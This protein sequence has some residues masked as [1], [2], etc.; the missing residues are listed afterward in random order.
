MRPPARP[1]TSRTAGPAASPEQVVRPCVS[2]QVHTGVAGRYALHG[3]GTGRYDV[4]FAP[5]NA[6]NYLSASH[7]RVSVRVGT[8]RTVSGFLVAGGAIAGTV[9][10]SQAGNATLAGICVYLTTPGGGIQFATTAKSGSYSFIRLTQGTYYVSLVGGCG[11]LGSY[12]PQFYRAGASTGS[13]SAATATPI[14]LSVGESYQANVAMLPGGTIAG[15]VTGQPSGG[16]LR[17]VCVELIGQ[18]GFFLG[19]LTPG[20]PLIPPSFNFATTD[21]AGRY[22]LPNLRP[23]LYLVDFID[24]NS[25]AYAS[26]WFAPEGGIS[27]Q[28]LSVAGGA[29]VVGVDA[30]LP[31]S[32]TITGTITSTVGQGLSNICV[33]ASQQGAAAPQLTSLFV[34]PSI[35]LSG[36]TGKYQV[37][38]L[39][40]AQYSVEFAPCYFN[41]PYAAQWYKG[42]APGSPP[43]AIQVQSGH[44]TTAIN[45]TMTGGK[46]V[47]GVVI[48]GV[49]GKP[50]RA[51]LLVSPGPMSQI[52]VIG[53]QFIGTSTSGRFTLK[54]V[55][56]GTYLV[57]ASPC[58][59]GAEGLATIMAVIR[60]PAG[61]STAAVILRL[62]RAGAITGI[63]TAA[64]VPG[65]AA[66]AC[67]EVTTDSGASIGTAVVNRNGRYTVTDIAPGSYEVQI[68]DTCS[69]ASALAP[70]LISP[71]QVAAGATTRVNAAL[72]A[73]G[74]IAGTVTSSVSSGPVA[75]ICVAA[76][77]GA[78]VTEP[79]AVAISAA[80]GSYQIGYLAPGSYL[81]KFSSGC[82]ATSYVTQWY[83]DANSAATATPVTVSPGVAHGGVDASMSS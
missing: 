53:V 48:S 32:G 39:A 26:T 76:F 28:W 41:A 30:A 54:H 21:S 64:S 5:C 81:V 2:I 31:R 45:A 56:A 33:I 52:P 63:V 72:V 51:C 34:F 20:G 37:G 57:E 13:L 49:S 46:S 6:G 15:T 70:Q 23:G 12:A 9:N 74:S 17:N 8:T 69:G 82:P 66:Y 83:N 29:V 59:A 73:N 58:G 36:K 24:C 77:T 16:P 50:L 67:V 44:T 25:S 62:P 11:N 19:E 27:P 40:P 79:A 65:G 7:G 60:I 3:L 22:R 42:R 43:T 18:A 75:G 14:R 68:D 4:S 38:G 80:D 10:T 47:S 35:G 78:S 61:R 55:V 1:K 71:V